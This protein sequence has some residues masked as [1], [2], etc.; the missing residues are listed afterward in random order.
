MK[1]A[2]PRDTVEVSPKIAGNAIQITRAPT[3]DPADELYQAVRSLVLDI[4][5]TPKKASEIAAELRVNKRQ[6]EEWMKQLVTE[7][8]LEKR[9]KPVSYVVRPDNLFSAKRSVE[10]S[11]DTKPIVYGK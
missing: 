9:T 7:G 2:L 11:A 4:L 3:L 8:L 1:T 5:A 6:A 10:T